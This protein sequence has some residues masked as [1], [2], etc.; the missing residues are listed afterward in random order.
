MEWLKTP[1]I[2]LHLDS[3]NFKEKDIDEHI[4]SLN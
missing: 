2:D 1:K 4:Q 3:F